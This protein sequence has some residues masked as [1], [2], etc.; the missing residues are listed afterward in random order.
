MPQ[1]ATRS[2]PCSG[3]RTTNR[4]L[5]NGARTPRHLAGRRRRWRSHAA[6]PSGPGRDS[7][8]VRRAG[9]GLQ[10][11]AT[12]RQRWGAWRVRVGKPYGRAMAGAV[13]PEAWPDLHAPITPRRPPS[14]TPCQWARMTMDSMSDRSGHAS[15]PLPAQWAP[16]ARTLARPRPWP[17]A[18]AASSVQRRWPAGT[19]WRFDTRSAIRAWPERIGRC[20]RT[21]LADARSRHRE[22]IGLLLRD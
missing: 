10:V 3:W 19:P 14:S 16:D 8:A 15:G 7:G 17:A 1:T 13:R 21:S 5:S 2:I 11:R 22:G 18:T 6:A 9:T 20:T 4:P 12:Q